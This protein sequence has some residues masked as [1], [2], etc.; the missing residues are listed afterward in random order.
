MFPSCTLSKHSEG[1]LGSWA[2]WVEG[3]VTL[4]REVTFL[5]KSPASKGHHCD[6][7]GM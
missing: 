1:W 7:T 4:H 5:P 3:S 6:L 2:K